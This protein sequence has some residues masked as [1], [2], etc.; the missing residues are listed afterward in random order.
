MESLRAFIGEPFGVDFEFRKLYYYIII[1]FPC[2]CMFRRTRWWILFLPRA[3]WILSRELWISLFLCFSYQPGW[4]ESLIKR[5]LEFTRIDREPRTRKEIWYGIMGWKTKKQR[6]R[7]KYKEMHRE[8]EEDICRGLVV[9][10]DQQLPE[11]GE[12][13]RTPRKRKTWGM[14]R[15]VAKPVKDYS[16]SV[17][18]H[19]EGTVRHAR[20]S[21]NGTARHGSSGSVG[22]FRHASSGSVGSIGEEQ[23]GQAEAGQAG[24]NGTIGRKNKN[25]GRH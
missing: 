17:K 19:G 14:V 23:N 21:S 7:E 3:F 4:D 22:S 5:L 11:H 8:R 18:G 2:L 13:R 15:S 24:Q 12:E 9:P 6:N 1:V 10:E 16:G 25:K 20:F